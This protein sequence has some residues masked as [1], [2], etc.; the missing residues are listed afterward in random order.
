MSSGASSASSYSFIRPYR[1]RLLRSKL[2]PKAA[3]GLKVHVNIFPPENNGKERSKYEGHS[4]KFAGNTQGGA[5]QMAS[6]RTS[7]GRIH[8]T[9]APSDDPRISLT[10]YWDAHHH[11]SVQRMGMADMRAE[12]PEAGLGV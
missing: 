12:V 6:S 1:L 9:I 2:L 4:S 8:A 7:D 11:R 3:H 10:S 5:S